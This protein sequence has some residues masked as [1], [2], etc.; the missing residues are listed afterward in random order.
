[1]AFTGTADDVNAALNGLVY[2]PASNYNG[3]DTLT[4]ITNDQGNTGSGGAKSDTDMVA[5]T[6]NAVNDAPVN[7]VP[8]AQATNEDTS[9]TFSSGGGNALSVS[10]VDVAETVGGKLLVTL[11]VSHGTLSLSGTTG[12]SFGCV[13]CAGDGTADA[14]MAFTG[15]AADVNAALNGLVYSPA[16]NYNGP[17]TLTLITND[18]GNTGSGG[19]LSDTDTVAITVNAVNDA[20]TLTGG[21]TQ[22]GIQYSDPITD[23][24][25]TASDIDT[26][27]STLTV[28]KQY[29][30]NGGTPF[31]DLL[32]SGLS[33]NLTS[34]TEGAPSTA[35]PGERLWT[36]TGR[37]N[38]APGTYVVKVTVSDGSLSDYR[39]ATFT[40]KQEDAR[41]AS[42]GQ[43]LVF[44]GSVTS[45]AAVV[46]L[47]AT[48]SDITAL[49]GDPAYDPYGG[50]ILNA[51]VTF[52]N[53]DNGSA[54]ICTA[55][56]TLINPTD[57][58]VASAS[59]DWPVTISGV[60][61]DYTIGIVVGGYYTR[62]DSSDDTIVTVS[63]PLS[64]QFITG[65]GYL[66]LANTSGT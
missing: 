51:T 59:C 50:N 66:V 22:S 15:T 29:T 25:F 65:G 34:A 5:I 12:L 32:P 40:V 49:T 20:P 35:S 31:I 39:T 13:G 30:F 64:T 19:A 52:V 14:T 23:A 33:L 37:M 46:P 63:Q 56:L 21:T 4:L 1:M 10:D 24:A 6:V 48:I 36:L 28:S 26:A 16:A 8:V 11:S 47:R 44:T 58:K 57:P 43:S 62:D 42:T 7:V 53:R 54:P 3:A 45:S 38:V 2:L 18:Q 61:Q 17:E 27:G 55:T 9:K 41:A 60:S